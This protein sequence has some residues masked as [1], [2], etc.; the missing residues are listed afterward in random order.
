MEVNIIPFSIVLP[1]I[2]VPNPIVAANVGS[3]A[4]LVCNAMG[5]PPP[6]LTWYYGSVSIPNPSLPRYSIDANNSLVISNVML[7]DEGLM[8]VCQ[9]V[10]EAGTE[11]ATVS[12]TVNS[13]N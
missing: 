8:F 9:A 13:K 4:R 12:L 10:N 5:D 7:S 3:T 2:V 6:Q 11:S 1:L